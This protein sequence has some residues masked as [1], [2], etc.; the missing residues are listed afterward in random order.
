LF[1]YRDY[2]ARWEQQVEALGVEPVVLGPVAH[3]ELPA[4]VASAGVFAFPSTKEGF[5]LAAM[6]ALAAGVPVVVSNLPVLPEIFSG[7]ARFT[8]DP[9][10]LAAHLLTGLVEPDPGA[11]EAGQALAA[12]Y[13]WPAAAQRHLDLYQ[14]L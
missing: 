9:E 11:R 4:L 7:A 8:E 1:G 13:T 10:E 12:R 2:R 5:G 6:E 3:D 14:R